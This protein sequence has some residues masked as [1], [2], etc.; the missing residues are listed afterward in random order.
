MIFSSSLFL[1]YFLPILLIIYF[2]IDRSYKNWLLLIVSVLF[3]A[4]GAPLFVFWVMAAV[5]IDFLLIGQM[6]KKTG[7]ARRWL[8]LSLIHI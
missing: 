7:S 8:F 3:Y 4:W 1:L 6:S 2:L 5:V